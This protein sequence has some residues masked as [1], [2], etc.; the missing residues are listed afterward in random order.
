MPR[1]E[2]NL[3]VS[4]FHVTWNMSLHYLNASDFSLDRAWFTIETG[5]HQGCVL[6]PDSFA[7]SV[8]CLLERTVG[9]GMNGVSFGLHSFTDLDFA[10]DV[11]LLA[12]ELLVHALEMMASE[13]TS[14]KILIAAF[15]E[16]WRRPPGRP[17]TTWMKT[18]QQDLKSNNLS[19][20]EAIDVAENRPFWRLMSMFGAVHC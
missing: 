10:N 19:L 1:S 14:L 4:Y 6:A 20:N 2:S 13:A 11:T 16:N 5:V 7:T 9:T 17:R 12:D 8:V 15:L 3:S 18:I